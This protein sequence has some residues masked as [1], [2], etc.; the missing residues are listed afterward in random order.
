[1]A[2][3][4]LWLRVNQGIGT[5]GLVCADLSALSTAKFISL[6]VFLSSEINP[7][8]FVPPGQSSNKLEYSAQFKSASILQSHAGFHG[9]RFELG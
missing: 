7:V 2:G 8:N 3:F 5:D 4:T 6:R 1:M 9:R